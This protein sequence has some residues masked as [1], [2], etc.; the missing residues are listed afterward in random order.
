MFDPHQEFAA[1]IELLQGIS[2][3]PVLSRGLRSRIL[4]AAIQSQRR[5]VITRRCLSAACLFLTVSALLLC[6]VKRSSGDGSHPSDLRSLFGPA[7]S[8]AQLTPA[9]PLDVLERQLENSDDLIALTEIGSWG[10]VDAEFRIRE[11]HRHSLR[12]LIRFQ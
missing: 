11:M 4:N 12:Q 10:H 5:R 9:A 6:C 3:V 8:Y 1:E 7:C 2:D